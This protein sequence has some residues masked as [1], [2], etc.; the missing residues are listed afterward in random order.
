M[1]AAPP[2]R[3]RDQTLLVAPDQNE[4]VPENG[5]ARKIQPVGASGS[6]LGGLDLQELAGA[7]DRDRPRLHCLRD[8]AHEVDVQEAVL[9][10]RAL[11]LDMVGAGSYGPRGD[12]LVEHVAGLLVVVGLL[13]AADRQPV[14]CASIERSASVK[15]ATA[16]EM[17]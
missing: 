10:A 7:R 14:L 9:Q 16:T 13:R 8:L 11:D 5:G 17:R 1:N 3:R 15:P 4:S 2:A 6:D 12:A